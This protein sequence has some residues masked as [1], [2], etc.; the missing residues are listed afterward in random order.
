MQFY[1][2]FGLI[3]REGNLGLKTIAANLGLKTRDG[4]LGLKTREG[5]LG[6]NTR[7]FNGVNM[8]LK[9]GFRQNFSLHTLQA[10]QRKRN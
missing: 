4:N 1:V 8:R 9:D 10:K 5:N 6:L 3:T 7:E 2:I